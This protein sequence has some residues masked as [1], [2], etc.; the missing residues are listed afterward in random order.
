MTISVMLDIETLGY[1]PE[2]VILTLGAVRFDPR[3]KVYTDQ[4]LYLKPDV[5]QQIELG[6][7]LDDSTVD[8]WAQQPEHIREEAMSMDDRISLD[9]F[10]D[11]LNKFMVGVDDIWCQGPVFDI[12]ILENLYR[13]Q[14]WSIPWNYWQIR[15]SRTL[16]KVHG[17]PRSR[18]TNLK[19]NALEDCVIQ[20]QALIKVYQTSVKPR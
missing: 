4:A 19:H 20:A 9:K 6:R 3:G 16:F 12:C 18:D 5:D 8:W 15:D 14:G 17:D 13:S 10:H 2:C 7:C 1:R 11:D